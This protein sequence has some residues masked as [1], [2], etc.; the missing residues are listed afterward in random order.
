MAV[1][2]NDR[3]LTGGEAQRTNGQK[4]LEGTDL[5]FSEYLKT[6]VVFMIAV[7]MGFSQAAPASKDGSAGNTK[8]A[9]KPVEPPKSK[10][11]ASAVAKEPKF[12]IANI[13]RSLDPCTDFY[14]FSCSKW[15]KNNPI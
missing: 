12:D 8:K 6:C 10:A 2:Y 14:A 9:S 3:A 1:L 5:I 7:T 11:P 13:D 4:T 15:M